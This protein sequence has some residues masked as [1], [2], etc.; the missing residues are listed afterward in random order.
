MNIPYYD[1][2][3]KLHSP[4]NDY[5]IENEEVEN[6]YK[7]TKKARIVE[8]EFIKKK[9]SVIKP[10]YDY[11]GFQYI[12]PDIV[13]FI[14]WKE[15]EMNMLKIL[16]KELKYDT[17]FSIQTIIGVKTGGYYIG[18]VFK[19]LLEKNIKKSISIVTCK[20]IRKTKQETSIKD[21]VLFENEEYLKKTEGKILI[22]DDIVRE[23]HTMKIIIDKLMNDYQIERENILT[24]SI[25]DSP[26]F[27]TDFS[28]NKFYFPDSEFVRLYCA[29]WG[30]DT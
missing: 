20:T 27:R 5:M 7:E 24:F 9:K 25:F 18:H 29:P 23:G 30:F 15:M 12:K 2:L 13:P 22:L 8:N 3:N 14:S 4:D 21:K 1:Y 17:S 26:Q 28:F 16:E 11:H 19:N 6:E 10:I